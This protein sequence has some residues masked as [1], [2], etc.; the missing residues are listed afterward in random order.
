MGYY[1]FLDNYC[2]RNRF[3]CIFYLIIRVKMLI[4]MVR[5][6][7][8][9]CGLDNLLA[10]S[11]LFDCCIVSGVSSVKKTYINIHNIIISICKSRTKYTNIESST[12]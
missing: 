4:L 11:Y 10:I 12:L 6:W 1:L 3:L 2:F 9:C 8:I 7:R 5:S